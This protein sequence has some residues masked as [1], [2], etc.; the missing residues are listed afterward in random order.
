MSNAYYDPS[1]NP[2]TG[3]EGL[4]ALIR[5]EFVAISAAFDLLPVFG[6]N[7][8]KAVVINP[9][10]TAMTITTGTLAL[11]GNFATTGAF[12]TTL[13]QTAS[14]TLT[15]PGSSGTLALTTD[16][17]TAV[18]VETT[19]AEGA[20]ATL[21]TAIS[22]E[23]TRA[24]AA[25]ALLAPK[26]SP[27]LTGTPAA[28]TAT[29]GTN[30]TQL[31]T[32][33]YVQAAVGAVVAGVSSVNTRTGAVTLALS[34][35]PGA[36]PLASPALTGTPT[37][38]TAAPS[39]NTTQV[40]S[41]AF[42]AAADALLAPLASPAFSGTP[43]APTAAP[44]TNTTQLATTAFDT[45]AIAVETSRATTAEALLAPKAS[46]TFTGTA[47]APTFTATTA[48]GTSQI[49]GSGGSL[50]I[51]ST[52]V[53][54][55]AT[56]LSQNSQA[57]ATQAY[58]NAQDASNLTTAEN[59]TNSQVANYLPLSGGSV[60]FLTTTGGSIPG[61]SGW[62]FENSVALGTYGLGGVTVG[63]V[64]SGTA[65]LSGFGFF[66][67]SDV[68][69]KSKIETIGADEAWEWV[70]RS[71]PVSYMKRATWDAPESEARYEVGFIAQE[72]IAAGFER[73][74]SFVDQPG[75]P[76]LDDGTV[77]SCAD[78]EL[79]LG[80]GYQIAYLTAAL[81]DERE[82]RLAMV[83]RL[84]ALEARFAA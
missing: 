68:R 51:T 2:A 29:P 55:V 40:A 54:I 25:E 67:V 43:T 50:T 18:A 23:T 62:G 47:T 79:N 32:T 38:P 17:S 26:A 52:N 61:G 20:E 48:I 74:V 5:A 60:G 76:E 15:L 83:Q 73:H 21:S 7:A 44:G 8:G 70:N 57:L 24:E 82:Q 42:V 64:A 56:N 34:D 75:I 65:V 45:A 22:A 58:A 80:Q 72:Q 77:V 81:K 31:A 3:A 4:S 12:N 71:R 13:A 28:P 11:A 39:T 41:T 9:G 66:I 6:G 46:P 10:G 1:G 19:R 69:L 14:T 27:T 49:N 36:A 37:T 16:V 63:I 35:I 30:T 33:A 84:A 53:N 59:Y 78:K